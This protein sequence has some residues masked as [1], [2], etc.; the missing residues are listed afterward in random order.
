MSSVKLQAGDKMIIRRPALGEFEGTKE[1]DTVTLLEE[2]PVYKK[3]FRI[4]V[5]RTGLEY[6]SRD[7]FEQAGGYYY[8]NSY[9][10]SL[11][12]SAIVNDILCPAPSCGKKNNPDAKKCWWCDGYIVRPKGVF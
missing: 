11:P 3:S 5:D 10:F 9:W 6:P 12:M 7:L 4:R 1:G 2:H 8:D